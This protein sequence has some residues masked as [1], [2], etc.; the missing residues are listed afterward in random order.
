M[1]RLRP[2]ALLMTMVV[3]TACGDLFSLHSLYTAQDRVFDPA[4]EGKWETNDER[5]LVERHG[6]AYR[7]TVQDKHDP[8]DAVKYEVHLVDINGLHFADLRQEDTIGH[9]FVRLRVGSGQLRVSFFDTKW[10]R[11]RMPHEDSDVEAGNTRA[12]LTVPTAQLREL[13]GRFAAE[14]AAYDD[15]LVFRRSQ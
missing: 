2:A 9:M 14:S 8:S 3:T 12:V 7:A 1:R 10:L 4:L 6:D 11:D 15:E 13:V 5:L